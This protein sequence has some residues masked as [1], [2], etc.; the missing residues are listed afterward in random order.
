MIESTS[1]SENRQKEKEK[2]GMKLYDIK[3]ILIFLFLIRHPK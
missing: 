2:D 3:S 1:K